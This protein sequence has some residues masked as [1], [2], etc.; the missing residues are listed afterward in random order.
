MKKY[1]REHYSD[2]FGD[3]YNY[4]ITHDVGL[5]AALGSLGYKAYIQKKKD[6]YFPIYQIQSK[7]GIGENI[8]SYYLGRFLVDAIT[9]ANNIEILS[10]IPCGSSD[11]I[12]M[13]VPMK[14]SPVEN[15]KVYKNNNKKKLIETEPNGK[16]YDDGIRDRW[17]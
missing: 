1:K 2:I 17:S 11:F 6:N 14:R 15:K 3:E 10:N 12:S 7:D 9:L 13:E 5:A 16:H 8:N 4:F